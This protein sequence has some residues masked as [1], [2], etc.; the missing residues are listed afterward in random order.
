MRLQSTYKIYFLTLVVC[1]LTT[2]TF[3]QKLKTDSLRDLLSKESI[4]TNKVRLA[5]E[6]AKIVYTNNPD[7]ALQLA[8]DALYLSRH[9]NYIEGE[10]LSLGIL[11][12]TFRILGNYPRALELNLQKLQLEEK[13]KKPQGCFKGFTAK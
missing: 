1:C 6:L 13:R 4:D 7:T 5:V 2:H 11:A 8:Q 12:S 10:S 9:I 3:S